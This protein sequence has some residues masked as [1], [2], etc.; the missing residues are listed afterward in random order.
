MQLSF[1]FARKLC[2]NFTFTYC[3]LLISAVW[4]IIS[5]FHFYTNIYIIMFMYIY[6]FRHQTTKQCGVAGILES[7]HIWLWPPFA[8]FSSFSSIFQV[9]SSLLVAIFYLF[10]FKK[11]IGFLVPVCS[12]LECMSWN[13][14]NLHVKL[15]FIFQNYKNQWDYGKN[16]FVYLFIRCEI[17]Q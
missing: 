11:K 2:T 1:Q 13:N 14:C 6:I 12:S 5:F 9:L 3:L 4:N 15:I 8:G 7:W 17:R 16:C 10:N